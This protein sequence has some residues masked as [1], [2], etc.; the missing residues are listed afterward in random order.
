MSTKENL[1]KNLKNNTFCRFGKSDH[2]VGVFAIKD[3]PKGTELF[4]LCNSEEEE[5]L[6]D[7]SEEDLKGL[8]NSIVKY[9][10]DIFVKNEDGYSLP[11]RGMNSLSLGFF[12]N[13]SSTPNLIHKINFINGRYGLLVP[14]TARDIKEGEELTEDYHTLGRLSDVEKQ[15]PFLK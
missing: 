6:I 9:V 14:A 8:D 7:L 5:D 12:L 1:I 2:G 13:H 3:I 15:F 10:K 4:A 11:E